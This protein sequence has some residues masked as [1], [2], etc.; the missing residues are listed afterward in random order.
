MEDKKE[1]VTQKTSEILVIDEEKIKNTV[2]PVPNENIPPPPEVT[3][4]V[5]AKPELVEPPTPVDPLANK[6]DKKSKKIDKTTLLCWI[7][8]SISSIFILFPPIFKALFAEP[9]PILDPISSVGTKI[10]CIKT[11]KIE[12][13]LLR[14][15]I[16]AIYE[17]A[18]FI[19]LKLTYSPVVSGDNPPINL[20]ELELDEFTKFKS[21]NEVIFKEVDGA[22][23]FTFDYKKNNFSSV[24]ELKD[25]G[26]IPAVAVQ[27]YRTLGFRCE[28]SSTS[29][30]KEQ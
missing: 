7:G 10:Y 11:E 6:I 15:S 26:K 5:L 1:E 9:S 28:T 23:E 12:D 18:D 30:D 27:T 3:Q 20:K 29:N 25:H 13:Q 8:I 14:K 4:P 22:Y 2:T 17:G 24:L 16:S 21:M 19:E